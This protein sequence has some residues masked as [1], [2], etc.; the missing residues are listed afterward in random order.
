MTDVVGFDWSYDRDCG[1]EPGRTVAQWPTATTEPDFTE[2]EKGMQA[3]SRR[4][5][6]SWWS[7]D[8]HDRHNVAMLTRVTPCESDIRNSKLSED[9]SFKSFD[10][11]ITSAAYR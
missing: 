8:S 2:I 9:S 5:R 7:L 10:K 4:T 6:T 1:S 3:I 11:L